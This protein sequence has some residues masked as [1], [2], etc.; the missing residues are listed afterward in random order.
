MHIRPDDGVGG[1]GGACDGAFDLRILDAR[2]QGRERLR[3]VVAGLRLQAGP[4][5]GAAVESW[6]RAGLSGQPCEHK[7]N[8]YQGPRKAQ[9]RRLADPAGWRTLVPDMDETTQKRAG[10]QHRC[11]GTEGPAIS[12][13]DPGQAGR[14]DDQIIGFPADHRQVRAVPDHRLHGRGIEPS[15]GL[16]PRTAHGRSLRQVEGTQKV[17]A[18]PDPQLRPMRPSSAIDLAYRM[19]LLPKH[20][21]W[22][23]CTTSAP[24]VSKRW[25]TSRW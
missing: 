5:D 11:A 12:E 22:Q 19:P 10:C 1:F 21:R 3:R 7:S 6:W 25:V 9:S 4:I 23:D 2:R 15:I 13:P 8:P 17:D 20:T 14:V 16:R 24:M 18:L